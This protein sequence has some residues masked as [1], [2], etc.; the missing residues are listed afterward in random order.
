MTTTVGGSPK[1]ESKSD[2]RTVAMLKAFWPA[3]EKSLAEHELDSLIYLTAPDM[4]GPLKKQFKA[5]KSAHR[6]YSGKVTVTL[7]KVD[8]TTRGGTVLACVDTSHLTTTTNGKSRRGSA[9]GQRM[10]ISVLYLS[11]G[12]SFG[13][14]PS[15]TVKGVC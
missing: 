12:Q 2:K 10:Q 14:G 7:K 4:V 15:T 3:Y 11:S 5:D 6:E 9:S 13:V 1:L 8:T